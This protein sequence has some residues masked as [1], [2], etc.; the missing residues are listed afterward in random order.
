MKIEGL[1]SLPSV[2]P[3][4]VMYPQ[5]ANSTLI[6]TASKTDIC[7]IRDQLFNVG[8]FREPYIKKLLWWQMNAEIHIIVQGNINSYICTYEIN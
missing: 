8:S 7:V 6:T 3:V 5:A 4:K 1:S 2:Y